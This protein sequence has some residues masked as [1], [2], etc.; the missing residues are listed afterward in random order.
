MLTARK[1]WQTTDEQCLEMHKTAKNW[2]KEDKTL[3]LKISKL[4]VK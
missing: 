2:P 1:Q 3:F 4:Q